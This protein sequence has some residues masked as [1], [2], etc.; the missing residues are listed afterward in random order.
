M[1]FAAVGDTRVL[2]NWR[3]G[4]PSRRRDRRLEPDADSDA[5][6]MDDPEDHV[7]TVAA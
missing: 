2:V 1:R 5:D 4:P 7:S 6:V 3:T